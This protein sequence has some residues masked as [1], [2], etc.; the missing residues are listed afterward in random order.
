MKH[1]YQAKNIGLFVALVGIVVM[2]GWV[3]D[4]QILKSILPTWVTMKFATAL[5]F[6]LSGVSLYY[7]CEVINRKSEI[8]Q[9]VIIFTT[10][11]L[12]LLMGMLLISNLTGIQLGIESL[13]V[14]EAAGAVKTTVPGRPSFGTMVSFMLITFAGFVVIWQGKGIDVWLRIIG[15]LV[16]LFGGLAII[17]YMIDM[18][19]LYYTLEGF[20]TAMAMHTA[21]LFVL[22]GV[23]L[24]L[25]GK[26]QLSGTSAG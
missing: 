19:L 6:L 20:S 24:M 18:P 10:L 23:G 7:I 5:S 1:L 11:G 2:A 13:F 14:K 15:I 17:G 3:F 4:I 16:A 12:V 26:P 21:I 8:G 9:M 22:M 25:I